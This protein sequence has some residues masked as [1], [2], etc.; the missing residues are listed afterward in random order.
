LSKKHEKIFLE[1][2]KEKK[3][4]INIYKNGKKDLT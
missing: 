4:Y 1:H 2:I 3:A